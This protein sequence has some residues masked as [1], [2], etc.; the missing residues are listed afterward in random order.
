MEIPSSKKSLKMEKKHC[1]QRSLRYGSIQGSH[2]KRVIWRGLKDRGV[3]RRGLQG[4]RLIR[5][6]AIRFRMYDIINTSKY[7]Q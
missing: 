2:N 1:S 7:V 6:D 3:T 4:N 5:K